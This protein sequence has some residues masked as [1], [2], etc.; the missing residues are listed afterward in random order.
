MKAKGVQ[1]NITIYEEK[2]GVGGR[3]LLGRNKATSLLQEFSKISPED[4]ASGNLLHN[5]I[6]RERDAKWLGDE[7]G[8]NWKTNIKT[9]SV[10]FFDGEKIISAATRPIDKSGWSEWLGRIFKYGASVWRARKLPTGTMEGFQKLLDLEGRYDDVGQML[11][12]TENGNPVARTAVERLKLNGLSQEYVREVLGP[13]VKRHT[14]QDIEELSDLALSMALDREDQGS[15]ISD[16]DGSL[17]TVL[18]TFGDLSRAGLKFSTKVSALRREMVTEGNESWILEYSDTENRG[19]PSY[20]MFDKV[21]IAAPWNTSAL[22][23]PETS[24]DYEQI[25]YRSQ[26]VTLFISNTTLNTNYFGSSETLPAQILPIP[27]S[28]MIQPFQGIQE[29]SYL[30]EIARF[31]HFTG[32]Y[33]MDHLYRILSDHK[34]DKPT[35]YQLSQGFD[36]QPKPIFHQEEIEKAY[37]LLYARGG[38]FPGFK[39][40]DGLWHTSAVESI[41]SSV[42]LS[43]V[44]GENV[45]RLVGKEIQTD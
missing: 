45:A 35:I 42:D 11:A 30:K 26:W 39:I 41:G 33:H 36:H 9:S 14:G 25:Q 24:P 12:A 44:A 8:K 2:D 38:G 18:S 5:K 37:S 15:Q 7:F 32:K 10:G 27:S 13:Q 22:L 21:I 17:T 34:I 23:S 43:W 1:A 31:D 4:V 40:A 16:V 3:M 20:E 29:I 19:P 6:L 28:K